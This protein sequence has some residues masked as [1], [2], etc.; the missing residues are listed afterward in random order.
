MNDRLF[1]KLIKI[2]RQEKGE[3]ILITL[4]FMILGF[5][6][7]VP[8]VSYMGTG[9]KSG[10]FFDEKS[11][12]LYA[13][14][15]GVEDAMWKIKYGHLASLDNPSAYDEYNFSTSWQ[16]QL[17]EQKNGKDVDVTIQN[18][19][20]PKNISLPAASTARAAAVDDSILVT[21]GTVSGAIQS[22]KI[23]LTY[24]A[25]VDKTLEIDSIGIWLPPGFSY[26]ANSSN[27]EESGHDYTTI[28]VDYE[29]QGGHAIIWTFA[30][31]ID[32]TSLPGVDVLDN[33]LTSD[34]TFDFSRS[35]N[36][37]TQL[38]AGASS[39]ATSI[40][41]A[42]TSGFPTAGS[43]ILP[44]ESKLIT[45]TAVTATT[46]SGIPSSGSGSITTGHSS[47]QSVSLPTQPDA[48]SWMTGKEVDLVNEVSLFAWDIDVK[49]FKIH[50]EAG[51]TEVDTF[52]SKRELRKQSGA[53]NGEYYATG[54]SLL[55]D[56]NSDNY[57][58]TVVDPST[59]SVTSS[60]IPSDAEVAAAY[61]YWSAWRSASPTFYDASTSTNL[62]TNLWTNGGDW[63]YINTSPYYYQGH[64]SGIE[65][66]RY[67]TQK[68]AV[69]LSSYEPR[70]V[71]LDWDQ[72][73]T[74]PIN[75]WTDGCTDLS[76]TGKWDRSGTTAYNNTAWGVSS[77]TFR[78]RYAPSPS[79]GPTDYTYLTLKSGVLSLASA[80]G[81]T[82][83]LTWKQWKYGTLTEGDKLY[84][85][86][87]NDNFATS[88]G[89][90]DAGITN[91]SPTSKP[92]SPNFTVAI[93]QT[94][95]TD[96][97][98]IRFYLVG[99]AN[100]KYCYLDDITVTPAYSSADGLDVDLSADNGTTWWGDSHSLFQAFR[101][102]IGASS[103][104]Y[105]LTIPS[106]FLTSQFKMRLRL[107]G[108]NAA[109]LYCNID[110]V[111]ILVPDHQIVFKI[112]GSQ[113]YM[114]AEGLPQSGSSYLK[115]SEAQIMR[116][117]EGSTYKG[118]SYSCY[119]DVTDLVRKYS[120]KADDPATNYPGW[121]T[122]EVR[123]VD[124]STADNWSYAGWSL[125]IV[126][127]SAETLGHQLFLYDQ[128]AYGGENSDVDFD[129]DG[130]AGGIISGFVVPA[131]VQ[132]D[133]G[134]WETNAAKLTCFVGEGDA[135]YTNDYITI[136]GSTN[137]LS[138][139]SS[140]Y[141]N[142]W[143]SASHGVTAPG[144]DIDTFYITW[145]SGYVSAGDTTAQIHMPTGTDSWNLVY[146]I[147]S[148]RNETVTGGSMTYLIRG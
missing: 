76:T 53:I 16:Y 32:F 98:K 101:G 100:P 89:M 128:L 18:L 75:I 113:V 51:G 11:E 5:L 80:N 52:L 38:T 72:W 22:L 103:V 145:T 34:I 111:S 15:A 117:L 24:N 8:M 10:M 141:N 41:V 138:N 83:N 115:A 139:S 104:H 46:F 65:S 124:A 96:T 2:H 87:S 79:P 25:E 132:N 122:Y 130:Q 50:S 28:P 4:A 59:A 66:R 90:F 26:T 3:I 99:F 133:D 68:T 71:T 102:N 54:N 44:N 74:T 84:Y 62:S 93:P 148:F 13:A 60:N 121:G 92:G 37:V 45:Y 39:G 136:N 140:P 107:V 78:G 1:T 67:V 131:R 73:I 119:R 43:L 49:V 12:A 58:D 19:W 40:T 33:P 82:V 85:A 147:L 110:N 127:T 94:Y 17:P 27:L 21:T 14:D 36:A 31:S 116:N 142:V 88:S 126:Y 143:N 35:G 61:L 86:F 9:L 106:G 6:L 134:S 23:T 42:S 146:I 120:T 135:P 108:M 57:R 47:G 20:M 29:Y 118:Y 125:V 114:D 95:L 64:H 144:L 81:D 70:M 109:S 7:I 91:S 77:S 123:E 137:Y 63:A 129:R 69:N 48:V 112:N 55:K 97:M 30:D 105:S 56:T